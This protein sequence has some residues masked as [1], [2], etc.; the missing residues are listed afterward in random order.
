[1]TLGLE[2][3]MEIATSQLAAM[4]FDDRHDPRDFHRCLHRQRAGPRRLTAHID[5]GRPLR[6]DLPRALQRRIERR[7]APAVG[8][9]I[10]RHV[11]NPHDH[12]PRQINGSISTTPEHVGIVSD[13]RRGLGRFPG[14]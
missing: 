1:M 7:I 11:E 14:A 12:G 4:R 9:R 2:V 8:K 5:D 10:R 3:S 13:S 6:H